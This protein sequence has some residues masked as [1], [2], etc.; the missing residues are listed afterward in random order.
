MVSD[1]NRIKKQL[2]SR[3]QK[4]SRKKKQYWFRNCRPNKWCVDMMLAQVVKEV[5]SAIVTI[6]SKLIKLS[7][8]L[9]MKCYLKYQSLK[10]SLE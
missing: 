1:E 9:K 5:C 10:Q 4:K 2:F 3:Q 6:V 8:F 7:K